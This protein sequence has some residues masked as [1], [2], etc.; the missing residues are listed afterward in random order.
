MNQVSLNVFL[1]SLASVFPPGNLAQAQ[2]Q[3]LAATM[4]VY[5]FP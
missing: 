1:I 2:G 3:S 4:N 5:V